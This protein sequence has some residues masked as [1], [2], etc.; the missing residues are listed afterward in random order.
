[1][2]APSI[3]RAFVGLGRPS[4]VRV[5]LPYVQRFSLN[6]TLG[7]T[8]TQVFR[9]NSLF[10]PDYTGTG[11]QPRFFDQ[12]CS[13]Y[14]NYVVCGC[15]YEVTFT[16]GTVDMNYVIYLDGSLISVT[17]GVSTPDDTAEFPNSQF[18][19]QQA[20]GP[21]V[22]AAGYVSISHLQGSLRSDE[23]YVNDQSNWAPVAS[24]PPTTAYLYVSAAPSDGISS[25]TS[26]VVVK[27]VYDCV[28]CGPQ[29]VSQS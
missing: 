2:Q 17:P 3:P 16:C 15:H 7:A 18:L 10:D 6:P 29:P 28:M 21:V 25:A 11:H 19:Q 26:G 9:L 5:H 23:V 4:S 22:R 24:N 20:E 8:V 12:W 13:F 27:L 1:M 14:T